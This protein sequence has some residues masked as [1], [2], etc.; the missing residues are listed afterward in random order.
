MLAGGLAK[1]L[2]KS[3]SALLMLATFYL[4]AFKAGYALSK[5]AWTITCFSDIYFRFAS[6]TIFNLF[7]VSRI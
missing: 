1:D 6:K 7:V 4:A 2:I 3:R 5:S